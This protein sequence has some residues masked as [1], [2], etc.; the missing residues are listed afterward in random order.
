MGSATS[1]AP[2][3]ART[4]GAGKGGMGSASSAAP[5]LGPPHGAAEGGQGAASSPA[6]QLARTPGCGKAAAGA[7]RL[8]HFPRPA[9]T[10]AEAAPEP[11]P[12]PL[13]PCAGAAPLLLRQGA[14]CSIATD[15]GGSTS[16]AWLAALRHPGAA[17]G[18]LVAAN[19][20]RPGGGC[21]MR[22]C[23]RRIRPHRTHEEDIVSNWLFTECG[24]EP[25]AM[26][27]LYCATINEWWGLVDTDSR[28]PRTVQGVDYTR[29]TSAAAYADVWV[30][31]DALLCAKA[32]SRNRAPVFDLTRPVRASLFFAGGPNAGASRSPTGSMA[33]TLN[34][35][36]KADYRFFRACVR[37]A[38]AAALDAMRAEGITVAI[39]CR[40]SAGI[41]GGPH[42]AAIL[43]EYPSLVDSVLAEPA[44]G[45]PPR[46]AFFAAVL[47]CCPAASANRAAA[48]AGAYGPRGTIAAYLAAGDR[49]PP[50]AWAALLAEPAGP[51]QLATFAARLRAPPAACPMHFGGS[52]APHIA[53][54]EVADGWRRGCV[55]C[56]GTC[57]LCTPGACPQHGP[58]GAAERPHLL[59]L[60]LAYCECCAGDC[61]SCAR[62]ACAAPRSLTFAV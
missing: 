10:V 49:I 12:A 44:A 13:S 15:P 26:D 62:A 31:R 34:V 2:Q 46:G 37:A 47:L 60:C 19:S 53:C 40:L 43:A 29:A 56:A 25:A 22:G 54:A 8:R 9:G 59:A 1:P 45:G 3:L 18:V 14:G 50:P 27:Q 24:G 20:G 41:Y 48:Q 21:G 23:V 32:V 36:A 42:R 58:G 38:L 52:A 35:R 57:P 11:A 16:V 6:P 7:A 33:R 30:V 61:L 17:V 5:Q 55:C 4:Q 39:L 51:A 28:S